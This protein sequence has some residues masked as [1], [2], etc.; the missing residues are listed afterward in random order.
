MSTSDPI[1][2]AMREAAEEDNQSIVRLLVKQ[3]VNVED[4][5][6]RESAREQY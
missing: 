1:A 4:Q 2:G 5:V 3:F 6:G